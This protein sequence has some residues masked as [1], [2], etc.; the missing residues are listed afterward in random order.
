MGERHAGQAAPLENRFVSFLP[1]AGWIVSL[2][3]T[4]TWNPR[5]FAG[6]SQVRTEMRPS[7]IT[8]GPKPDEGMVGR[9]QGGPRVREEGAEKP[10]RGGDAAL[11]HGAHGLRPRRRP[12]GGL[13]SPLPRRLQKEPALPPP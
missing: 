5:T 4:S 7:R 9:E 11:G 8:G 2:P 10:G 3:P 6:E 12:A 13:G 1:V